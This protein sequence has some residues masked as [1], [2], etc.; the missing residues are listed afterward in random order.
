MMEGEEQRGLLTS[1]RFL[2]FVKD[3][4]HEGVVAF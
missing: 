1:E 2:H 4:V 3:E